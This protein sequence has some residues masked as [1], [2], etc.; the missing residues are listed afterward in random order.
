MLFNYGYKFQAQSEYFQ[1]KLHIH[2]WKLTFSA[3]KFL[4]I[5][6]IV[7]QF[8]W[9]RVTI[10]RVSL[11]F[12][13]LFYFSPCLFD[14]KSHEIHLAKEKSVQRTMFHSRYAFEITKQEISKDR[15]STY[16]LTSYKTNQRLATKMIVK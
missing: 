11:P 4:I 13:E 6:H 3:S 14:S 16:G 1:M 12:E 7:L 5:C 9:L 10:N 2:S 8:L 15:L